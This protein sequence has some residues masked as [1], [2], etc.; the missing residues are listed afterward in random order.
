[1]A[2]QKLRGSWSRRGW[3]SSSWPS[4]SSATSRRTVVPGVPCT[5]VLVSLARDGSESTSVVGALGPGD[6]GGDVM[7]PPRRP[8]VRALHATYRR[9]ELVLGA[10]LR[11]SFP[12]G[13]EQLHAFGTAGIQLR[14]G[15]VRTAIPGTTHNSPTFSPNDTDYQDEKRRDSFAPDPTRPGEARLGLQRWRWAAPD[16]PWHVS[17]RATPPGCWSAR[18]SRAPSGPRDSPAAPRRSA[19]HAL[20]ARRGTRGG[21]GVG[22]RTA[23]AGGSGTEVADDEQT[24]GC[25]GRRRRR[26]AETRQ[27][28]EGG[29]GRRR[30]A[31]GGGGRRGATDGGRRAGVRRRPMMQRLVMTATEAQTAAHGRHARSSQSGA[32]SLLGSALYATSILM[33][34]SRSGMR[35]AW[36]RTK[37]AETQR[38][39]RTK[40]DR[41][42]H[43]QAGEARTEEGL[44]AATGT[45]GELEPAAMDLLALTSPSTTAHMS[46][47]EHDLGPKPLPRRSKGRAL[48]ATTFWHA[49]GGSDGRRRVQTA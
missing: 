46:N 29:V 20:G 44:D 11:M 33:A 24:H 41:G 42:D 27:P 4:R 5:V 6:L 12:T 49:S 34:A 10:G 45:Q 7:E 28:A 22:R 13:L 26:R 17:E 47:D 43:T 1:M 37:Q 18:S 38:I 15:L 3:R 36:Y 9:C 30:A 14:R 19:P 23:A 32:V 40:G 8:A 21:G 25:G 31:E 39:E 48:T 16:R 2:R 35:Q